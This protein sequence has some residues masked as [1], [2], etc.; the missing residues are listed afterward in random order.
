MRY[1]RKIS[2]ILIMTYVLAPLLC[3]ILQIL[4]E[5]DPWDMASD[6]KLYLMKV[7]KNE[8]SCE[9]FYENEER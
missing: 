3:S 7:Q 5:F 9:H 1:P 2:G 8:T 6:A 4:I